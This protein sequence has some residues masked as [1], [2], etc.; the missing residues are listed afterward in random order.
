METN[1]RPRSFN[2]NRGTAGV[3][4]SDALAASLGSG[5][6]RLK[7][8]RDTSLQ[9]LGIKLETDE[10][11][12]KDNPQPKEDPSQIEKRREEDSVSVISTLGDGDLRG[13]IYDEKKSDNGNGVS[14]EP[15]ISGMKKETPQRKGKPAAI[16][17]I[18][19]QE[20]NGG[21]Q[22][23]RSRKVHPKSAEPG[24]SIHVR[25]ECTAEQ[26]LDVDKL[27]EK[28]R[29]IILK[30]YHKRTK[31][32]IPSLVKF[33]IE[34][35]TTDMEFQKQFLEGCSDYIMANPDAVE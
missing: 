8:L 4:G 28:M 25:L 33:L 29:E 1:D 22:S 19:P 20:N 21:G 17:F 15:P 14:V 23:K 35:L 10:P 16:K 32:G 2:R 5:G 18:S 6:E 3:T 31:I 13:Q 9:R 7:E 30:K 34:G 27:V 26:I 12:Q 24:I 11:G